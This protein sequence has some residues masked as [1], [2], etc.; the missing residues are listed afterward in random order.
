MPD[1]PS[2]D[3]A[4]PYLQGTAYMHVFVEGT[5]VVT[6]TVNT[7]GAIS[8]VRIAESS[9]K[10]IGRSASYFDKPGYFDGF[11]EMNVLSAVK[12]WRYS[13]RIEPCSHKFTFTFR[14]AAQQSA[15][16]DR[17]KERAPG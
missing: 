13:P 16:P 17:A 10:P 8:D 11:L 7:S 14:M 12:T 2:P 4:R 1:Y 15:E 9:Y 5:V 3:Q 6:F